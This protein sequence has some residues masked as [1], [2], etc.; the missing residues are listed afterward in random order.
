MYSLNATRCG[1]EQMSRFAK[2]DV[3]LGTNERTQVFACALILNIHRLFSNLQLLP[4]RNNATV[5]SAYMQATRRP[6]Q[7][8]SLLV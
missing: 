5:N 6:F 7:D 2:T 4:C 1:A 8:D 3:L